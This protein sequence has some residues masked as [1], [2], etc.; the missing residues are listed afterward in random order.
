[1]GKQLNEAVSEKLAQC[2]RAS[3]LLRGRMGGAFGG[4]NPNSQ[5]GAR[6]EAA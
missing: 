5:A 2:A 3:L 1:M 4:F 6:A